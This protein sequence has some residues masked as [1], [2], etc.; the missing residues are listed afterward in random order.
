[1]IVR[2]LLLERFTVHDRSVVDLPE[3]GLVVVTGKNGSGKSSLPEAVA[4]AM[5]GASLRGGG[6][7]GWRKVKA[8]SKTGV[9]LED[10]TKITRKR[11][12]NRSHVEIIRGDREQHDDDLYDTAKKAQVAIDAEFGEFEV[13]RRSCVL[14][15]ADAAMFSNATD[16]ERKRLLE[17]ILGLGRFDAGLARCREEIKRVSVEHAEAHA[18]QVKIELEAR[19]TEQSLDVSKQDLAELRKPPEHAAEPKP[20]APAVHLEDVPECPDDGAQLLEQKQ[21][22][23]SRLEKVEADLFEIEAK[24]KTCE[25]EV[26]G[27]RA[28]IADGEKAVGKLAKITRC[29]TCRQPID[30]KHVGKLRVGLDTVKQT[31][32]KKGEELTELTAEVTKLRRARNEL[33]GKLRSIEDLISSRRRLILKHDEAIARNEAA[34][35]R[36]TEAHELQLRRW[37]AREE[38]R[39]A[40]HERRL[41]VWTKQKAKLEQRVR[42]LGSKLLD[43]EDDL[44]SATAM[45]DEHAHDLA[46]LGACEKALGLKGIRA[47]VLGKSLSGIEAVANYWLGRIVGEGLALRLKPYSEK[48]TGGTTDAISFEVVGA[49][50]GMW[51]G[52]SGGERRRLDLALLFG[53]GETARAARGDEPSTI[54]CDEIFEALDEDGVP[55]VAAALQELA[56]DRCVVVIT[57]RQDLARELNST[58]RMHAE[59]GRLRVA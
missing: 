59:K 46:V 19:H 15:S 43:L 20:K 12:H 14:S 58:V 31:A 13:W 29:P 3:V 32:E 16:G 34:E 10:G 42:D 7:R 24:H 54:W 27:E 17:T 28:K 21:A 11:E 6:W 49:G 2:R 22:I 26:V 56:E 8:G 50:D 30:E 57:H 18:E 37:R 44:D 9:V 48:K 1:M 4:H 35:E 36:A 23:E 41:E 55:S 33:E 45:V 25:H 38:E 40:E 47:Q 53:L 52:S 51:I 5:W 39:V